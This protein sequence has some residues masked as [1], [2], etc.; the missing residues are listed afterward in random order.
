MWQ[1]K[2]FKTAKTYQNWI[3]KNKSKYQIREIFVNNYYLGIE[4]KPLIK[5]F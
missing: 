3:D 2:L 5:I 4:Y 1:T